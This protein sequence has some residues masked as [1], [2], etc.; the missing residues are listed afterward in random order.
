MRAIRSS[1]SGATVLELLIAGALVAVVL[2]GAGEVY[3]ATWRSF[4]D[5]SRKVA[6]QREATQLAQTIT[7]RVRMGA[8][9][10]VYRVPDREAAA[11]SGDGL[12]ILDDDGVV[13][14]RFEWSDAE[15]TVVDSLG[16]PQTPLKVELASFAIDPATPTTVRFAFRVADGWGSLVE[17]ESAASA[18]N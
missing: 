6:A 5:G 8:D 18:R 4:R 15:R 16:I 3:L 7:R 2:V 10:E 1:R 9:F 13:L 12:A 11:D 14:G 17:I